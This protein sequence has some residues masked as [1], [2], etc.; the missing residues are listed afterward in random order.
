MQPKVVKKKSSNGIH[1]GIIY[2]KDIS[3]LVFVLRKL[4]F[5]HD[6]MALTNSG[7]VWGRVY[8]FI[9]SIS[10]GEK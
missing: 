8:Q 6:Q 3:F 4:Y 10:L 2:M 7:D 9:Y 5:I 1:G